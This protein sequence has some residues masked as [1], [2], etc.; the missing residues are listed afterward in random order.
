MSKHALLSPSGAHRWL[1]CPLA[2]R[3]EAGLPDN[4]SEY[5]KEGTLAHSVCEITAKKHFKKVK[6]AEYNKVIKRLKANSLWN[7]E[8]LTTADLYVEHIAE[9][10]MGFEFEPYLAFEV[11]VDITA[12]VPEAFGTCD[13]VMVGGTSLVITDYKHGKGVPVSPNENPQLMLYALGALLLYKPIYGDTIQNVEIFIDQPRLNSYDGWS[14]SASDLLDWG[15]VIKPKAEQA[16]AGIG[17][18]HAGEWCRF[19]RANGIC[20]AQADTQTS[21]FSDFTSVIDGT[22]TNPAL[23]SASQLGAVLERGKTLVDWYE[24]VKAKVLEMLLNGDTVPGWKAVEGRSTRVWLDQD[25]ALETLLASGVERAL[26]FDNVPKSLAQLEKLIGTAKFGE[27][28]GALIT[29]PQGKP[30][31][32][33]ASD[34]R[35]EFNGAAADF[36]GVI[37]NG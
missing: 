29:K 34:A 22:P 32:A 21:A 24:N 33:A 14:C 16:F 5:A 23:L 9:R 12:Y 20:K 7:D 28:V 3:L 1:N 19:C 37:Q 35:K 26:I 11:K 10:A 8:M 25:K 18:Y 15:S 27:I 31:L 6:L 36:A 4:S 30:A 17:E 13:C 2:P